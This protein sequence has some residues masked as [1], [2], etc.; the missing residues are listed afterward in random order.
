MRYYI[1]LVVL[2]IKGCIADAAGTSFP[3]ERAL[4]SLQEW[5]RQGNPLGYCPF[6]YDELRLIITDRLQR[7]CNW[8]TADIIACYWGKEIAVDAELVGTEIFEPT[9][10]HELRHWMSECAF[11][12]GDGNHNDPRVWYKVEL[13]QQSWPYTL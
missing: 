11:G 5:K 2:L 7:V 6:E 4:W 9:I 12:D 3:P 1:V 10:E 13:P 8:P